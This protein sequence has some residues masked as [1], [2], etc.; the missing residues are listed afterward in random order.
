MVFGFNKTHWYIKNSWGTQWGD[1]GIGYIDKNADCGLTSSVIKGYS[2]LLN[3]RQVVQL[4]IVMTDSYGDGW[5]GNV[6]VIIQDGNEIA[7]F[8]QYFTSGFTSPN[9][10]VSVAPFREVRV[11]L[12]KMG[13][14][15]DEVGFKIYGL[16]GQLLT[17][18]SFRTKLYGG[19]FLDTFCPDYGCPPISDIVLSF[20]PTD[21]SGNGWQGASIAFKQFGKTVFEGTMLGGSINGPFNYTFKSMRRVTVEV[22]EPRF[23]SY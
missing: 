9:K 8:G 14:W 13:T 10:T 23:S 12:K 21:M 15:T 6:F 2:N 11:A 22:I 19:K 1:K 7:T 18:K 3:D 4:T 16:W 20:Y 17:E 5:N